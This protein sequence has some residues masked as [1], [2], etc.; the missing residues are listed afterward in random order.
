MRLTAEGLAGLR[1]LA[2]TVRIT[3]EGRRHPQLE[4]AAAFIDTL[5]DG[6]IERW[7]VHTAP[8]DGGCT[9]CPFEAVAPRPWTTRCGV[10]VYSGDSEIA[11]C[12]DEPPERCPL[13]RGPVLVDGVAP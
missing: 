11:C 12:Y 8:G 13:R 10:A 3:P 6:P 2:E 7:I 5:P 1:R 9:S 4:A